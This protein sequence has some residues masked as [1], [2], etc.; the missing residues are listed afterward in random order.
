MG[1]SRFLEIWPGVL[2][3]ASGALWLEHSKSLVVADLHLGYGWAQRRRGELG[4][5]VDSETQLKI[6]R[7][8]DEVNASTILL[9]GDIVHAAKPGEEEASF[10]REVLTGLQRRAQVIGIRGNH[11]RR[12]AEDFGDLQIGLVEQWR[13]GDLL[14]TH[15]DRLP[16]SL[17]VGRLAIGHLHPAIGLE[18]AAGVK[19]RLPAFLLAGP[20]VVLP[21]F[22]P[23]AAGIDVWRSMPVEIEALG[24]GAPPE[25]IVATGNRVV[26]LGR[27][28][29][30]VSPAR[31]SRP[32][33]YRGS[34]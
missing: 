4:P 28:S 16:S 12:F 2:A 31:G 33:D 26:K 10:V 24:G 22:S 15:G 7:V 6:S 25:V 29:R 5:L 9:A 34:K 32:R 13:E 23:F 30:L 21:A 11:D 17:P 18:D 27:L 20:V 3:H 14:V 1:L 8:L 19:Q